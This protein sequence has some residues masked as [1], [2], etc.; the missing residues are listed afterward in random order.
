MDVGFYTSKH[1]FE[2]KKQ[3]LTEA[4]Q[5][6]GLGFRIIQDESLHPPS[7]EQQTFGFEELFKRAKTYASQALNYPDVEI[8]I[9]VENSLSY[10]YSAD[11]WFY[12]ICVAIV[13]TDGRRAS[14]FTPGISVP[15][16]MIKEVQ[17]S[18]IK[19]DA[20]TQRLAGEDDPVA[21]F[22]GSTLTRK[23]LLIPAFLLAFSQLGIGKK[24]KIV[25]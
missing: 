18:G 24:E 9:G 4:M 10:L 2:A 17:D 21:Y 12:V 8:G 6:L 5:K 1:Y 19:I 22:S 16:W 15:F 25:K 3:A 14:S 20:L 7:S 13:T 11:E 23:D